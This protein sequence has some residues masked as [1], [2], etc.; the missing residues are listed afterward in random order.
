MLQEMFCRNHS[1]A[2]ILQGSQNFGKS[3]LC[4]AVVD[5][6]LQLHR[7]DPRVHIAYY[8]F[9]KDPTDAED[10]INKALEGEVGQ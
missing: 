7:N 6:L 10:S 5:R 2:M 9:H 3:Y 4:N 1:N 8:Y